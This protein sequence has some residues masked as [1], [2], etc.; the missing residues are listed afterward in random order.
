[1]DL[2]YLALYKLFPLHGQPACIPGLFGSMT[3]PQIAACKTQIVC[4]QNVQFEC[5]FW[6]KKYDLERK[7]KTSK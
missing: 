7:R 3:I 1:M 5:H 2:S 4:D 6:H